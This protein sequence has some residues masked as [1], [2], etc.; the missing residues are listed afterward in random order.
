MSVSFIIDHKIAF[1]ELNNPPLNTLS[2]SM[3]EEFNQILEELEKY[4]DV[5]VA[6]LKSTNKVF[7]A[8]AD[9]KELA[10]IQEYHIESDP[11]E[12]W[13]KVASFSK[14]LICFIQGTCLGGGLE[15]AMM[16]DFIFASDTAKFGFPEINL[17]LMPGGGGTAYSHKFLKPSQIAY[18]MM[19]GQ[20]I[21]ATKAK[22]WGLVINVFCEKEADHNVSEI[23]KNMA[24]KSL[25]AL[26]SIKKILAQQNSIDLENERLE[27]Y[28][29]LLSTEG[30]IG[31]NNFLNLKKG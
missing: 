1:I 3:I 22:E 15:L 16:C 13:Q 17:N 25:L 27:F 19:S 26:K 11:M 7:S 6:V 4:D 2:R 9:L 21:E 5:H 12:K 20:T 28:K 29:L 14:P 31:I 10:H 18:L 30:Q 23:A 8:G 24:S